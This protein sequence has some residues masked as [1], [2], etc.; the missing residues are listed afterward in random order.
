MLSVC[1]PV[2]NTKVTILVTELSR[3]IIA[4]SLDAEIRIYDDQSQSNY[5]EANKPIIEYSHVVYKTMDKNLGRAAIRNKLAR[6][7][8]G[9]SLLF[10]D[11]DTQIINPNFLSIYY[12]YHNDNTVVV[13]GIAYAEKLPNKQYLL[14]WKYGQQR[15]SIKASKRQQNPY[16][17]F[18]T[19]NVL[20]PKELMLCMPFDEQIKGYGHEDTKLGYQL[21]K[22]NYPI[23]HIDNQVLHE[24]L[25]TSDE[26]LKKTVKGIENLV[27]LWRRLDYCPDFANMVKLLK[28]SDKLNLRVIQRFIL[29]SFNLLRNGVENNLRSKAPSLR[30]FDYYKLCLTLEQLR[31]VTNQKKQ[32]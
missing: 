18:L 19:G 13:G 1:I 3:Q 24:G 5:I 26:F 23:K 29:F 10:I 21:Y 31:N 20:I 8:L 17:T 25:E 7:A 2:Y 12:R 11:G 6:E 15:E 9:N 30:V 32:K 4:N 27:A 16:K 14:R 28:I 22:I